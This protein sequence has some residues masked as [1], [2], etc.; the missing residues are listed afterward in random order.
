[1]KKFP[2]IEEHQVVLVWADFKTGHVLDSSFV[3]V[4]KEDQEP[5]KIFDDVKSA[6]EYA[7]QNITPKGTL[8]CVIHGADEELLHYIT[9]DN[10]KNF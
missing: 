5:F 2:Q 8:E 6:V 10:V 3:V 7:K 9:P 1:M 4:T